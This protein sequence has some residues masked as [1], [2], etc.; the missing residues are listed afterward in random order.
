[1]HFGAASTAR[2]SITTSSRNFISGVVAI[3][4]SLR[5][6]RSVLTIVHVALAR[7]ASSTLLN[8]SS[9]FGC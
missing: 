8:I 5:L 1:M 7:A 6:A 2:T 3:A 9:A 4:S